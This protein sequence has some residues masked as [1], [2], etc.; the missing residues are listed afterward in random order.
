VLVCFAAA[1]LLTPLLLRRS[2]TAAQPVIDLAL[3]RVRQFRL[4][5]AAILSFAVAFYGIL[6]GN[7]VFL[8]TV[9]GYSVLRAAL[10]NAPGPLLVALVA[11]WASGLA[12]LFG[13]RK[14]LLIGG[15]SWAAG[16]AL[17]AT[18][19]ADSPHWVAHWLPA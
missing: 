7:I 6:L 14:V 12:F 15:A 11:R 18:R 3:F 8:Q 5:N 2:A 19:V 4:V 13:F 9:W 1:V 17:L 10:A 16:T